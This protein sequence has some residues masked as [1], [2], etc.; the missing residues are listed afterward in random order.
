VCTSDGTTDDAAW[1]QK[2]WWTL[3]IV[4]TC[5]SSTPAHDLKDWYQSVARNTR[6]YGK[7]AF[8]NESGRKTA[9]RTT[10]G[11]PP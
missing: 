6:T 3:A 8:N 7:P 10:T 11:A 2:S 4:H 5:T 1:P 9:T